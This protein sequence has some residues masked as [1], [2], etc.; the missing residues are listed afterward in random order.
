VGSSKWRGGR[1]LGGGGKLGGERE[2]GRGFAED[3]GGEGE[4]VGWGGWGLGG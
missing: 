3:G 2:Q 4:M 1:K